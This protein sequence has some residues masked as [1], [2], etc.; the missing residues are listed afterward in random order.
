MGEEILKTPQLL[1][2]KYRYEQLLGEGTNGKT[3]LATDL[4][5]G[6]KLAIKALKLNQN[7]SFKSFELFKREAETLASLNVA[8]IPKFYESILSEEIGGECY[9]VQE[10]IDAPSIQSLLAQGRKFS[11]DETLTIMKKAAEILHILHTQYAPPIIHR[12]IKPSN[13]LINLAD[14]SHLA[15]KQLYLIDFGAVANAHSNTDK[16]TIAG[17]IGYMAP[18]QNFGECL[19][20]TDLYALGATALHMLTGVPPYEMAFETFSIKYND[21]LDK[22]A[23]NTSKKMRKLLGMLLNYAYDKRPAS[24][25]AL[26]QMI[27]NIRTDSTELPA[28][29]NAQKKA[30]Q[31]LN[32]GIH[33]VNILCLLPNLLIKGINRITGDRHKLSMLK[34]EDV[35]TIKLSAGMTKVFEK[36]SKMD[37]FFSTDSDKFQYCE[38]LLFLEIPGKEIR[39]AIGTAFP[40]RV[41][42]VPDTFWFSTKPYNAT[43]ECTDF[44]FN[45]TDGSTWCGISRGEKPIFLIDKYPKDIFKT[46]SSPDETDKWVQ[47]RTRRAASDEYK[48]L[49]YPMK[50]LVQYKADDPSYCSIVYLIPVPPATRMPG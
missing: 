39:Y 10:Y 41:I 34:L 27:K 25:E 36:L 40:P 18:E 3:Y 47:E 19:P 30:V 42:H 5:T 14:K 33:L 48:Q 11:E 50:C 1:M 46:P 13:I 38:S 49:T 37:S 22:Y 20:Q 45:H 9:I 35:R 23:P 16:S 28:L 6:D 8:G 2:L 31:L 26:L 24:A 15:D 12:D 32:T 43:Y 44:T 7:D 21:A 29:N 4:R 17:T